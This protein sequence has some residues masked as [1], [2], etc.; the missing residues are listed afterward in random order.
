MLKHHKDTAMSLGIPEENIFVIEN[1]G[2]MEFK[3][4]EARRIENVN[5]GMFLVDAGAIADISDAIMRERQQLSG[6]GMFVVVARINAQTGQLL[7]PPDVISRGFADPQAQNGLVD[8]SVAAVTKTLERTAKRRITD[9]EALKKEIRK[10][11]S[12][13]LSKKT[14]KRPIILPLVVEV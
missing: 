9:A 7:G 12:S 10:D 1:G 8:E 2:R 11:L 6:D 4:G 5:A 14:R 3:N 13:F